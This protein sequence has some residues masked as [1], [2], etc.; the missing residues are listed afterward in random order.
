VIVARSVEE[1]NVAVHDMLSGNA[2]GAAGARVV[3][4]EFLEGEE[5][6]FLAFTDGKNILPLASAQDHSRFS[7]TTQGRIPAAWAPTRPRRW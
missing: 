2:F 6:S 4:E 5:A 7:T 1:A 3:I